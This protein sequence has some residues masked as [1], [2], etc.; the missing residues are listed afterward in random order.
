MVFALAIRAFGGGLLRAEAAPALEV[1]PHRV[2]LDRATVAEL[3]VLPGI[4]S[5][6][7]EAI[8]LERIRRGP[9][10]GIDALARVPGLGPET[11]AEMAPWLWFGSPPGGGNRGGGGMADAVAPPL[12]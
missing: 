4:G 6:R 9:F 5:V 1:R 8:V 12:R 7:A 3:R 10:D 11:A 2:D